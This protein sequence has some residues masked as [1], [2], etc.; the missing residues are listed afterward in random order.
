M[1]IVG[2]GEILQ[3][4][5]A[6]LVTTDQLP[7]VCSFK[8]VGGTGLKSS[9]GISRS[10]TVVEVIK[11]NN[12]FPQEVQYFSIKNSDTVAT[13]VIIQNN[14]PSTTTNT[15]TELVRVVL[16]VGDMLQYNIG[17]G[18]TTIDSTGAL[19][20][21]GISGGGGGGVA[22][23]AGTQSASSGTVVFSNSNNVTFGMSNSSVVTAS[24]SFSQSAQTQNI[25]AASLSGNTAG[26]LA[27]VSSGTLYL[28]GG[29]N[30]TLSQ[31]GN[32]VTFS[33]FSQT[34]QTQN[35]LAASLSGN[36]SGVLALVSSGTLILAGG[37]NVTLS[38]NANS[39]TIS[40]AS[41]TV[42][43]QNLIAVS[44]SGNTSG[45]LA[46][47]SSGTL[48]LAGGNN[49]TL[50]QAGNAITISAATGLTSQSNQALSGS[51]GSF[52]FQTATFGNLNG[53]SF[54]TSNGSMV[55]SHDG[56]TSQSNQ[57]LSGSNGSFTFQTATF[58]NLNNISF[59]TSNGS[60]VA[61][62]SQSEGTASFFEPYSQ[63][64]A[65]NQT[66]AINTVYLQP[67][68][69]PMRLSASVMDIFA[70]VGLTTSA[71]TNTSYSGSFTFSGALYS[72][73]AGT[74]SLASSGSQS[75]SYSYTSN[76][77]VSVLSGYRRFVVPMDVNASPGN[78]WYGLI[79]SF[80]AGSGSISLNVMGVNNAQ[81]YSG[82][83]G[84]SVTNT[85]QLRPYGGVYSVTSGAFPSAIGSAEI[86][87]AS[88]NATINAARPIQIMLRNIS[89]F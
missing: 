27:L 34:V 39:V 50:S 5:L 59:Y 8:D 58:G 72:M 42:Q 19:K 3:F 65:A 26:V 9:K 18:W 53:L 75:Y 80:S 49:I 61:S 51:N 40:A 71:V 29:N 30:M 70:S 63:N 28:A 12:S 20:V 36:T 11:N 43:T 17:D 60:M 32:S 88:G 15:I 10:T 37:N 76:D 69:I 41:Q 21:A 84:Q 44:L 25:L 1:L 55:G 54:Y 74:L 47:V 33:A 52:T 85:N 81:S 77:S 4:K 56:L 79:Y 24:A 46:L 67:M 48:T 2:V 45:A 78:Y 83:W 14:L 86:Y 7:F 23:S 6:A 31:N 87:N 62:Y 57:A 38:Q 16:A 13:T 66:F 64:I 89:A 82:S 22:I 35:L 73:N 68:F